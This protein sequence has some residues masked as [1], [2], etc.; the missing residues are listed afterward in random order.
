MPPVQGF[1]SMLSKNGQ[2]WVPILD[3]PIHIKQSYA[4]FD[5]GNAANVWV[6]GIDGK[7]YAGQVSLK[8][9]VF[10]TG[11]KQHSLSWQFHS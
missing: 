2:R 10:L 8:E 4:A 9:A 1:V 7:P 6:T 3:P 11:P 5:S